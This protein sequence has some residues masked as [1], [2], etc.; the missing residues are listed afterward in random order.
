[1]AWMDGW[2]TIMGGWVMGEWT[3]GRTAEMTAAET[4]MAE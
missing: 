2:V 1:M 4:G 3:D